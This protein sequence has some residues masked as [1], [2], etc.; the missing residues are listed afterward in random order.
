[1][2]AAAVEFLFRNIRQREWHDRFHVVDEECRTCHG[3]GEVEVMGRVTSTTISMPLRL[4]ECSNIEC[5]RGRV[6]VE[7]CRYCGEMP[8]Y[9]WSGMDPLCD[10]VRD[11][12]MLAA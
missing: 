9:P 10:C 5:Y 11:A 4:V 3:A 7:R 12:L 8:F 1:M 2:S 6:D